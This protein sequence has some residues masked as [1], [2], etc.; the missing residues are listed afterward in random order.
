MEVSC[1][2]AI[3]DPTRPPGS[4]RDVICVNGSRW[5]KHFHAQDTSALRASYHAVHSKVVVLRLELHRV[6][7]AGP[8]LGVAVQKQALVVCD[9]VEHLPEQKGESLGS[10]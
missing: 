4:T 1:Y 3:G 5:L 7:V 9:P 8:D 10:L 2:H 6:R